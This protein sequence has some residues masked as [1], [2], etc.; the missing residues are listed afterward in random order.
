MDPAVE[1]KEARRRSPGSCDS[2]T[3]FR[4]QLIVMSA[5]AVHGA[6]RRKEVDYS[7]G[8]QDTNSDRDCRL[9]QKEEKAL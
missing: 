1:E 8:R 4:Q 3:T 9:D 5:W 7:A 2:N 6:K